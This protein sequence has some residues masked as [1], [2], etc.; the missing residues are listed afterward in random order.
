M[1]IDSVHSLGL[2]KLKIDFCQGSA[3]YQ[4]VE[5]TALSIALS[6]GVGSSGFVVQPSSIGPLCLFALAMLL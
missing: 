2:E 1:A 4:I 5:L 3:H 6:W